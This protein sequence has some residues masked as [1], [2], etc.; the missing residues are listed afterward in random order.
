[1]AVYRI[2]ADAEFEAD[3]VVGAFSKLA[4]HFDALRRGVKPSKPFFI[5]GA[6]E[7]RRRGN[8]ILPPGV[9]PDA[10]PEEED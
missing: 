1:M 3:D 10:R 4:Q 8:I 7:L 9:N 2:L 6:V 5:S